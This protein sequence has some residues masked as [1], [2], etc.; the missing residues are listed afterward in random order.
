MKEIFVLFFNFLNQNKIEG[1]K[2]VF[3]NSKSMS[4]HA[5]FLSSGFEGLQ[6]TKSKI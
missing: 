5:G 3:T 1:V 4:K 2:K 6:N